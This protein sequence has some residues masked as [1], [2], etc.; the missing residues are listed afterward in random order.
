MLLTK[1]VTKDDVTK[2]VK[3]NNAL[4]NEIETLQRSKNRG[5][6][7]DL[8]NK[9]MSFFALSHTNSTDEIDDETDDELDHNKQPENTN[10]WFRK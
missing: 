7:I 6:I 4:V 10:A 1:K 5:T 2:E 8:N 9:L 3:E